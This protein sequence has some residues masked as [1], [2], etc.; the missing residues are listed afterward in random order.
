LKHPRPEDP[1]NAGI[2]R[3]CRSDTIVLDE[4]SSRMQVLEERN[5]HWLSKDNQNG[6]CDQTLNLARDKYV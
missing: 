2:H 3:A 4:E 5:R 1:R 6:S